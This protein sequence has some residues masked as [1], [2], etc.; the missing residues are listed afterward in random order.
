MLHVFNMET[1]RRYVRV[2]GAA[3]LGHA[4]RRDGSEKEA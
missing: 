4:N 1:P 2:C 3:R